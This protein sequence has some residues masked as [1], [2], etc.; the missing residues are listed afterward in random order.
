MKVITAS[1][2][3]FIV[4]LFLFLK[5]LFSVVT[6]ITCQNPWWAIEVDFE[7]VQVVSFRGSGLVYKP[8]RVLTNASG[9]EERGIP[10]QLTWFEKG[11]TETWS[12][13][14]IFIDIQ[15]VYLGYHYQKLGN[16][17]LQRET[18]FDRGWPSYTYQKQKRLSRR[19]LLSSSLEFWWLHR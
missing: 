10:Q 14:H 12:P 6:C 1:C 17:P 11:N 8:C 13:G 3:E 5:T 18:R 4:L 16:F 2:C 7:P 15:P 19:Y 9:L